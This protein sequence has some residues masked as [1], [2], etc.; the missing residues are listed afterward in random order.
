MGH[1]SVK[2]KKSKLLTGLTCVPKDNYKY[3]QK[4]NLEVKLIFLNLTTVM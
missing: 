1:T 3:A 4:Q 2:L